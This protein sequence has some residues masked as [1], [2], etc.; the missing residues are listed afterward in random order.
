[1]FARVTIRSLSVTSSSRSFSTRSVSIAWVRSRFFWATIICRCLFSSATP[2]SCSVLIRADS[3][4]KRSSSVTLLASA[5]SRAV[6]VAIS[7]FCCS[8]A[9]AFCLSSWS[10]ASVA[11]T[12]CR[13]ISFS[14]FLKIWLASSACFAVTPLINF[15]PIESRTLLGSILFS[16]VCSK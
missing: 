8:S 4:F 13:L 7:R 5:C 12:S 3:A 2:S 9:S 10:M 15:I 11:S 6:M 14:L 1:M 16:G